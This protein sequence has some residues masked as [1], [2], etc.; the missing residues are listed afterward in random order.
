MYS[1]PDDPCEHCQTQNLECFKVLGPKKWSSSNPK[2]LQVEQEIPVLFAPLSL[3]TDSSLSDRENFCLQKLFYRYGN[4]EDQSS[5]AV[6]LQHL[7]KE[8]AVPFA[9]PVLTNAAL[10][11]SCHILDTDTRAEEYIDFKNRLYRSIKTCNQVSEQCLIAIFFA[12]QCCALHGSMKDVKV[13]QLGFVQIFLRLIGQGLRESRLSHLYNYL[14]TT[15][16]GKHHLLGSKLPLA[17]PSVIY[18][19]H[20]ISEALTC[21]L[22]VPDLRIT[23]G[24]PAKY[25]LERGTDPTLTGLAWSLCDDKEYLY[26]CFHL[27]LTNKRVEERMSKIIT[28][29]YQKADDMLK[30]KSVSYLFQFVHPNPWISFTS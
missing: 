2:L 12:I 10:A 17:E 21:P 15:F 23:M 18:Q 11:F 25:W 28:S 26:S 9:D 1:S 30:L 14:L 8:Y 20:R 27:S 4:S 19:A 29:L 6:V 16:R 13:L 5:S 3:I 22:N 7:R 24:L